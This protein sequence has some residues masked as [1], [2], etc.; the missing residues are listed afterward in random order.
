M[1]VSFFLPNLRLGGAERVAITLANAM[2]EQG[3]V[4]HMVLLSATGELMPSLRPE[5]EVVDLG[6]RRIGAGFIPLTRYLRSSRA[7]VVLA[8]MWPLTVLAVWARIATR[9]TARVVVVEHTTWSRAEI[10]R[11]RRVRQLARATMRMTFPRAQRIVA[12]SEG[13]AGDLALFTGIHRNAIDVIHNPVTVRS[14][15]A[16][17]ALAEPAGWW[18][19]RHRRVLAVGSLKPVKDYGTLLKAF[20]RLCENVDAKLLILGEGECRDELTSTTAALG[21]AS[22][23]FMPGTVSDPA[24]YFRRADLHVL[25]SRVEG[26]PMV[27]LEALAAGTPVVSTDCES[28]P[29]ELLADG[30]YGALVPVGDERALALA[31]AETLATPHDAAELTSRARDFTT[32]KVLMR[33][34]D[35]F[36]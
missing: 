17:A 28:G 14:V 2:V 1:I 5:V 6:A 35:L 12:V 16:D 7:D 30:H 3:I 21:I 8:S 25:S 31:M 13:V 4:V 10:C 33:Y 24:P 9:S 23:V 29:R 22:Q 34:M 27:I 15:A 18:A 20:A 32:E 19:G 11:S 26:L 36:V